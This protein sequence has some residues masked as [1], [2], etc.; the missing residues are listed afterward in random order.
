MNTFDTIFW[1]TESGVFLELNSIF[2][3]LH[4]HV[5]VCEDRTFS[6]LFSMQ[7]QELSVWIR[8]Q[9]HDKDDMKSPVT[10]K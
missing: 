7:I 1:K 8:R 10:W 6:Q 4:L 3:H 5:S 2:I 9:P